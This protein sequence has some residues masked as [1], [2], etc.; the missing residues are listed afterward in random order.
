M[1]ELLLYVGTKN[2]SSWSLRPWLALSMT[3]APFEE[4]VIA[5]DKPDTRA[6]IAAVSPTGKVPL[7]EHGGVK[8]WDS[9]AICEYIA[10]L[11]PEAKLWPED[12]AARAVARAVSA[13]MHAGFTDLR[14]EL[15]MDIRGR[16]PKQDLSP[17]VRADIT[18]ILSLWRDT[19][20]QYGAGGAFLFGGF[21]I[22]DAMYAPVVTR[23]VTYDVAVDDEARAY[24]DA[25]LAL[26]PMQRWIA[27]A[28]AE[29]GE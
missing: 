9:L 14:R 12:R 6:R 13:E 4:V 5:L 25:I 7:L 20:G 28:E 24:M 8:V 29:E 26:P 15:S 21:T 18:R 22:A 11:F 27:G 23:F 2:L 16:T 1:G 17:A 19:R 3:G 10:E